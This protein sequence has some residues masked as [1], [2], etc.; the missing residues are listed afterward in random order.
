M[1]KLTATGFKEIQKDFPNL[2][3]SFK[4]YAFKYKD[5]L[6]TF[7]E[8][9]SDK[10]YYFRN[11]NNDYDEYSDVSPPNKSP[12]VRQKELFSPASTRSG[13]GNQQSDE[14]ELNFD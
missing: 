10:I 11:S 12:A 7:L 5:E 6:R 9:E 14:G 2:T 1:A 8:I 3:T 4:H 13:G